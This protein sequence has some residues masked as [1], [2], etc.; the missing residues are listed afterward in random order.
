MYFLFFS[1]PFLPSCIAG[2]QDTIECCRWL[3]RSGISHNFCHIHTQPCMC[4]SSWISSLCVYVPW[5]TIYLAAEYK[6]DT[7]SLIAGWYGPLD[8][9]I[10]VL[11]LETFARKV[12]RFIVTII[13]NE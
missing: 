10:V 6:L 4:H 7:S 8:S 12:Q 11:N 5:T 9:L 1:F 13:I 2:S 3:A